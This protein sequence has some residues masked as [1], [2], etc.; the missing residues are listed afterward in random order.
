[1]SVMQKRK[2]MSKQIDEITLKL[3]EQLTE[4]DPMQFMQ[5]LEELLA[6]ELNQTQREQLLYLKARALV[7]MQR[8]PEAEALA[9]E[10][11]SNAVLDGDH[12]LIA[13]C[14]LVLG[15]CGSTDENGK[16]LKGYLDVALEAAKNSRD[17][18]M[19]AEIL[20]HLGIFF[21]NNQD[22][23]NALKSFA[24]AQKI[25]DELTD[26][27]I[28]M[29]LLMSYGTTH[30][31][32]GEHHKA[33]GYMTDAL[34]LAIASDDVNRQLLIINNLSTLYSILLRFDDAVDVLNRGIQIA[35]THQIHIRKVLLLFNLGVLHLRQDQ[36]QSSYDKLKECEAF[37]TAIGFN[38]PRYQLELYSNL[39]GACRF[40]DKYDE[41]LDYLERTEAIAHALKDSNM[42]KENEGNKAN[43][44]LRMG[45]AEEA[46]KLLIGCRNFFKKNGRFDKLI[47]AQLNLADYYELKKDYPK[48]IA[49][50]K[51]ISP[52]Y[53]EYM[54]KVLDEKAVEYDRELN[55]QLSRL[56][57][58]K[59]DFSRLATK[60]N[61]QV[62]TE[63]IGQS[64]QYNKVLE[65]ALLAAQHPVASVLITGESGTGK[66]VIANLIHMNGV[67][68][69]GPFIAVNVSA[70]TSSL[71]ES[72]FFGHRKGSF[73]GA[74]TDHKGFFQQANHGTLFLDEIGDMPKELQSKLL[75]VLET[76][77][78][79]PVGSTAEIPVDCRVICSTNRKLEEMLGNNL[80]RLDLF[81][82][83]NTIEIHIPPLR[84]R[85]E[86]IPLLIEHFAGLL[87]QLNYQ[88]KP[89]IF[90][91]FI[92]RMQSYSF[93]GNVR[94]LRNMLERL[95][96]LLPNQDWNEDV[97]YCLPFAGQE[98]NSRNMVKTSAET[99]IE[100]IIMALQQAGGKQKEA[101]LLLNMSESTLCRRIAKYHL[102][103]YTRKG[104]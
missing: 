34:K 32:A 101:A 27:D 15:K 91:A 82:R 20:I 93:P 38:D 62:R 41:S 65:T 21:Q 53:Q 79:T 7:T 90:P 30:Y 54:S 74:I 12:L 13:K 16:V 3:L 8:F 72:E 78:V 96:I 87:A 63:F 39:A 88:R 24:R 44:L 50:L 35:E 67:R 48:A 95:F 57:Q 22:K 66:E 83:L 4:A 89:E 100:Q 73:T 98:G 25:C 42:I 45:R 9:L 31:R 51:E 17:N 55:N 18:R 69:S 103:I 84:S 75:R 52:L 40:L 77:K 102:E 76:R 46:R 2:K 47:V 33:L 6:L 26:N 85:K 43:L 58:V 11:L 86:D 19:I 5:R 97:I 71:M 10:L 29:Q 92:A 64:P 99:E 36:Y 14:N 28:K 94:E 23:A 80:F 104:N 70:I 1:M 68:S 81:H 61:E 59:E 49:L 37:A 60:L 56:D